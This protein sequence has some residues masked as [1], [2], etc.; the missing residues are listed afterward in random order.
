MDIFGYG[1][2]GGDNGNTN[3]QAQGIG[4][5]NFVSLREKP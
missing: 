5:N 4:N 1:I 2:G 3:G